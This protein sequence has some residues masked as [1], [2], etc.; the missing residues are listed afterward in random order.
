MSRHDLRR[1][2][3]RSCN[4]PVGIMWLDAAGDEKFIN[5]PVRNIS[6]SGVSLQ[7]PEPVPVRSFVTLCADK[8]GIHGRAS[9]RYCSRNGIQYS[10]GLEFTGGMRWKPAEQQ[11][12]DILAAAETGS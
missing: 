7:I 10:I 4:Q 3:R 11:E 2:S 12:E 8:L 9:V 5:A 1:E 6:A